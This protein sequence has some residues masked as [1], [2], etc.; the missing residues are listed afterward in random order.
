M[1]DISSVLILHASDNIAVARRALRSG[2]DFAFGASA[3][4]VIK[5]VLIASA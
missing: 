1:S 5:I 4:T 3:V 2:E